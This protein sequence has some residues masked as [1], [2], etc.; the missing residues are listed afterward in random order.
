MNKNDLIKLLE[1][2]IETSRILSWQCYYIPLLDID[3]ISTYSNERIKEISPI[4]FNLHE[5][6]ET[7][8]ECKHKDVALIL[9]N[10][11]CNLYSYYCSVNGRSTY[12][13]FTTNNNIKKLKL[14]KKILKNT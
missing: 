1:Y 7:S 9:K 6:I 8:N 4:T 13:I 5:K 2:L 14:M 12:H 3:A 11:N 10:L